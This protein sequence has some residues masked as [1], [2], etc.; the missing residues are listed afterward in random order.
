MKLF[1]TLLLIAPLSACTTI[2]LE[3]GNQAQFSNSAKSEKW[4]HNFAYGLYEHSKPVDLNKACN[5]KTWTKVTTE[6]TFING[7]AASVVNSLGPI[8]YPKTVT[9]ECSDISKND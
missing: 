8:W 1:K 5:D 6:L 4:H 9:I 3:N 2:H 7:L